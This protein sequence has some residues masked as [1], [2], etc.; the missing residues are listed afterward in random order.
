MK[1]IIRLAAAIL[2]FVFSQSHPA[3]AQSSL[4]GETLHIVRA[5]G[6]IKVDGNLSDDGWRDVK[7]VTTWYEVNPGDNTPPKMRNVGR[8][9][10][11][12]R[13][14]YA[15][16]EFDDPNPHAIRAPYS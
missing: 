3:L 2:L 8:I 9:A 12:D 14:L 15:A 16:F 4:S 13:Y 7:P 11:D 10:Y 5:T 6:P 1:S